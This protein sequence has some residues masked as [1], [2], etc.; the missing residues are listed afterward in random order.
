MK[1]SSLVL[2]VVLLVAVAILYV[3]YFTNKSSGEGTPFFSE[4]REISGDLRIAYIKVDSLI[5]NYDLSQDLHD[6]FAGK[7]QAYTREYADK[8]TKFEEQ[9]A[10]FQEKV[11]R[12]GFLT[13]QRAIQERDR[14]LSEE[15]AVMQLDQEL[16]QRLGELQSSNN[17]Q[18]LDSILNYLNEYN[19]TEI[20]T[21]IMSA[22]EIL[23]G[24]E[25]SNITAEVL[26]ALNAR[27]AASKAKR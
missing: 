24:D 25:A 4:S 13:Q 7:Q 8:R 2:H 19:A 3:L 18:L 15:Q 16:S 5:L 27:Y 23:I 11:Q 14:L 9:A 10:A 21:Y 26:I 6:D 22:G 17:Q 1:N 20:Y 12:G